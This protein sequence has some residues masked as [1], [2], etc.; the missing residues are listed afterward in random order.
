MQNTETYE[1]DT[2]LTQFKLMYTNSVEND[3]KIHD[4]LSF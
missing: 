2:W 1:A 4:Y 3:K